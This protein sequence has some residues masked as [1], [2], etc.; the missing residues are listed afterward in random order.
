MNQFGRLHLFLL[1]CKDSL[2]VCAVLS[3]PTPFPFSFDEVGVT[4]GSTN[5]PKSECLVTLQ[6]GY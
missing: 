1:G 4:T 3:K 2:W 6:N 5:G